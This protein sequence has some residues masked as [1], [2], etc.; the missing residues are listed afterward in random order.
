M[1][2]I[3]VVNLKGGVGKTTVTTNLGATLWTKK[4]QVLL[5]DLDFQASL[6]LRCLSQA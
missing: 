5:I 2:I 1:P 3:S 4:N 6:T